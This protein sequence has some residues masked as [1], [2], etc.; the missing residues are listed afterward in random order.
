MAVEAEAIALQAKKQAREENEVVVTELK[1]Q[2]AANEAEVSKARDVEIAALKA[3]SEAEDEKRG[4]EIEVARRV[5]AEVTVAADKA[6]HDAA[7]QHA[8]ELK[9][10]QSA[11]ADQEAKLA[12][13]RDAEIAARRATREAEEAKRETELL[14]ERRLDEERS[15]VRQQALKERDDEYRLKVQEKE[16]QLQELKEKLMYRAILTLKGPSASRGL[17]FEFAK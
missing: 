8:T 16:L 5:A 14:I 15:K 7:V 10:M 6:R 4:I 11:F 17:R 3:K 12:E 9:S 2:M 1:R 13:A